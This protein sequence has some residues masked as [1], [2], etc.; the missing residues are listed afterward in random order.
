MRR[1]AKQFT[2][3]AFLAH[4]K[5]IRLNA[6]RQVRSSLA[7]IATAWKRSVTPACT[8]PAAAE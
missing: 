1:L 8:P 5:A 7:R 6:C 2:R 4:G 3:P